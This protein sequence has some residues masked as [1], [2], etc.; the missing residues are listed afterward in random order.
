[1]VAARGAAV[2]SESSLRFIVWSVRQA[3]RLE[4]TWRTVVAMP[5]RPKSPSLAQD[6]LM[7]GD[8]YLTLAWLAVQR[9]RH[10]AVWPWEDGLAPPPASVIEMPRPEQES[11]EAEHEP[12]ASRER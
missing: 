10:G 12:V 11:D 2:R 6:L 9:L 7:L 3:D 1:M 4:Q 8:V 5:Q